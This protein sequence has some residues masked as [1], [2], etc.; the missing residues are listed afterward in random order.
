M[1]CDCVQPAE[2][3]VGAAFALVL[4]AGMSTAL[5]AATVFYK[6]T[7]PL[8]LATGLGLAAGVMLCAPLR[9]C[10]LCVCLSPAWSASWMT[11]T[12]RMYVDIAA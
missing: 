6:K 9:C 1:F 11:L 12:C 5:G 7:S 3:N 4:G 8:M 2:G 10:V